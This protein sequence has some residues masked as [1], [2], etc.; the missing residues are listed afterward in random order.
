[1]MDENIYFPTGREAMIKVLPKK[2]RDTELTSSYRPISLLN[3]DAKL[4]A[5]ILAK[6]LENIIPTLIHHAQSGF[7]KGRAAVTNIRKT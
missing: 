7:V 3:T 5:K 2:G 6:R 4:L 1:M